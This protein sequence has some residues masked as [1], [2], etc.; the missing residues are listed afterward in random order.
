MSILCCF[1]F[2]VFDALAHSALFSV[3]CI[4]TNER[5]VPNAVILIYLVFL[6]GKQLFEQASLCRFVVHP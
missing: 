4:I 2:K 3:Y 1:F 5:Q 6:N